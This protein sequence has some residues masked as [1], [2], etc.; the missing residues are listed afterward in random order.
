MG[1]Y[2]TVHFPQPVTC[3]E[4]GAQIADVQT[5][6]FECMMGNFH[7]GDCIAHA[8][9]LRVVREGLHCDECRAMDKQFVYCVV[10]RG[11]LV[12][13]APNLATAEAQLHN[14]PM[15]RLILWYHDQYAKRMVEQRRH[16]RVA[17]F[18]Q[19]LTDWYMDDNGQATP[20][21]QRARRWLNLHASFFEDNDNPV[22]AV[23][24][25]LAERKAENENED[26]ESV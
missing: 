1:V 16:F 3:V 24:A 2:D 19:D 22:D 12:D 10:N 6:A 15:E 7:I 9:E 14:S 20:K 17:R 13:I 26:T 18:L 25:Y 23:R 4:C 11:I 8:E 21:Q 5:K